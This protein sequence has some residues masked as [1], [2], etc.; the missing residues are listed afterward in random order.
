MNGIK[1]TFGSAALSSTTAYSKECTAPKDSTGRDIIKPQM[2]NGFHLRT[3]HL[4]AVGLCLDYSVLTSY[5]HAIFRWP[6]ANNG[7]PSMIFLF[8]YFFGQIWQMDVSRSES[9]Q[10]E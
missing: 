9:C 4:K 8:I 10:I 7:D 6:L 3:M 5:L 1:A 2:E